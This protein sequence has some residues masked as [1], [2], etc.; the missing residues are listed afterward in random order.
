MLFYDML[1]VFHICNVPVVFVIALDYRSVAVCL[2]TLDD[3]GH[4]AVDLKDKL[5]SVPVV[6]APHTN[7]LQGNDAFGHVLRG[8]LEVVQTAVVEDKPTPL[9]TFPTSAL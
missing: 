7:I 2:A 6:D 9:P 8:V 1:L 5:F 4:V 3:L